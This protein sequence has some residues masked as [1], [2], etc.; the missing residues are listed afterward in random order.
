V[1]EA[2]AGPAGYFL[3]IPVAL[4]GTLTFISS[5]VVFFGSLLAA[6]IWYAFRDT[7]GPS[8]LDLDVGRTALFSLAL[9]ASSG[10][11]VLA[12]RRLERGD[13]QGYRVWLLATI[14]LGLVFLFGQM[15]EYGH[16]IGEGATISQNLFT[17][18]F[19]TATG[20][21]GAHVML[22]LIA[23]ATLLGLSWNRATAEPP[24]HRA[25]RY[26]AAALSV[27]AYWHFVDLVW[28]ALFFTIYLWP[29]L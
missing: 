2:A 26:E 16:L 12:D 20:F 11:I 6:F 10:T 4:L 24:P 25:A 18:A 9:F 5:E 14:V 27:S 15:T 8:P 3:R 7:A 22:G 23:I 21:H 29:R 19:Y 13:R 17:S 28:V 1:H